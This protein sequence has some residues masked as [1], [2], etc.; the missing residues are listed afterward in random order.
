ME[1]TQTKESRPSHRERNLI[2]RLGALTEQSIQQCYHCHKCGAGCPVLLVMGHGPDHTLRL[3][4]LGRWVRVL[5]SR[6]VWL[7][8]GCEMCG[9]YC[10]NDI[11][12]GAVM[13]ALRQVAAQEGYRREDCEE[14]REKL[15]DELQRALARQLSGADPVSTAVDNRLCEGIGRRNY[16]SETITASHNVSGDENSERLIWP[17]NLPHVPEGLEAREGAEVVYFVGCVGAFF[18]RS[19]SVPQALTS[20]LEAA[21]ADFTT[22]AGDEWCCGYPM[23][24]LGEPEQAAVLARHNAEPGGPQGQEARH[25]RADR[26]CEVKADMLVSA[27]QQ[28]ERTLMGAVRR[29]REARKARMRVLDIAELVERAVDAGEASSQEEA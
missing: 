1:S 24:A 11:D 2:E 23:L 17:Q 22:L 3:L 19:Y 13:L 14:L 18:P 8:L 10:P 16:L 25:H 28:C 20:V 4:Q 5:S 26:A 12:I 29:H 27:C 7:C 15:R 21:E 9:A 6:D